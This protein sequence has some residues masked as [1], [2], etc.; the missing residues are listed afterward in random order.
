[1]LYYNPLDKNCKSV[2]G[3]VKHGENVTF[4][5]KSNSERCFFVFHKDNSIAHDTVPM[6]KDGEWFSVALSFETGLYWYSFRFIDGSETYNAGVGKGLCA[7]ICDCPTDY[8]LTVYSK[9]FSVPEWLKGGIIYQIFPDRFNSSDKN[10]RIAENKVL[11]ENWDDFPIYK[12][13]SFGIVR[14]NDFFGGDLKGIEEKLP[15]LKEL[16]VTAVYLN[17]IFK[18]NSNHRYDTGNYMEIDEL[19]GNEDD[20]VSLIDSAKN[21]GIGIILDG[22]FNHTGD[23]S[24]YFN[25]YGNYQSVGAYQSRDSKYY[26]W[27]NFIN[28]PDEYYSWWG[29]FTLPAVNKTNPDFI[30]YITGENGVIDKYTRLGVKG[31]R[32]DVVDELPSEFVQK[33]RTAVK[34]ADSSAIV[35]G[36]VWEDASNKVSYGTRRAYFQ[37]KELDSVMNYPLKNAI[38]SYVKNGDAQIVSDVVREQTDH[39]PKAVCDSLMNILSTHDTARILSAVSGTDV[40]GLGKDRLKDLVIDVDSDYNALSRLKI[41][42]TLQYTLYGV[43]S[44]YYGDEI[45][46]QGYFDPANRQTFKWNKIDCELRKFFVKLGKIRNSYSAFTDGEIKIVCDKDGVFAFRRFDGQ[47]D[48]LIVTNTGNSEMIFEFDGELFDLIGEKAYDGS[49]RCGLNDFA[50]LIN[51]KNRNAC[52]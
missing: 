11:H 41:A 17:P 6:I 37:G 45:G 8:Q 24:L 14:N 52:S 1:M 21:L 25:R 33:I 48:L 49:Y 40:S 20:F 51:R 38:I 3:A 28:Y 50:I 23:D 35:I 2:T 15:Y 46:M 19:L 10:K 29:I 32:L 44:L 47:S 36:E 7:E 22:V 12:P 42:V 9:D 27:Y 31:W 26:S 18:A 16:G 30:E 13:D 34:R 43:P 39:Y 5:I 4:R